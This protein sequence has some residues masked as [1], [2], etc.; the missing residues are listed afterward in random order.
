MLDATFLG[1]ALVSHST[2]SGVVVPGGTYSV[3][4]SSLKPI[5]S[6]A[7]GATN[8]E[9]HMRKLNHVLVP[10]DIVPINNQY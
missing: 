1:V 9:R 7:D 3:S 6:R 5:T 8:F 10:L 4:S 2:H